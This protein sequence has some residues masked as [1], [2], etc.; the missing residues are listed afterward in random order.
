MTEESWFDSQQGKRY[1]HLKNAQTSSGI[2][3]VSHSMDT[4][5]LFPVVKQ[6]VNVAIH[7]PSSTSKVQN[8]Y[9]VI[10]PLPHVHSWHGA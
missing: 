7:S 3:P 10:L 8:M 9:T 4:E 1:C 6:A 2:N 5:N